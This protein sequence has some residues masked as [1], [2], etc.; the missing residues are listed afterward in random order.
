M[1]LLIGSLL[2]SM[3]IDG[4]LTNLPYD[5]KLVSMRRLQSFPQQ[6]LLVNVN[7]A[8]VPVV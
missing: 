5:V 3:P 7:V 4:L 6:T 8:V 1:L 2:L